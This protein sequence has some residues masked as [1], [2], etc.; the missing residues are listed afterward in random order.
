MGRRRRDRERRKGRRE[1]FRNPKPIILIV[2]EGSNTEPQYLAGVRQAH[3]NPRVEIEIADEHGVPKTLVETAKVKKK[4]AE[5]N[6]ARA[7][8]DD[9]A[10]DSVWCVFDVDDHPSLDDAMQMA[11]ANGIELAVS[12]P[13]F[14]LWLLLH[15][16]DSPGMLDRDRARAMLTGFVPEYDKTIAFATFAPGYNDAV[17]RAAAL[18]RLSEAIGDPGRNPTT[19][20]YKLTEM[21]RG[22]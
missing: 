3:R 22:N 8:D 14:E 6:A 18:D 9:L 10:Y 11:D 4:D 15:F 21:I 5:N 17:R 19:G 1:P 20:V 13:C 2:C 16:R 12:N 7:Q